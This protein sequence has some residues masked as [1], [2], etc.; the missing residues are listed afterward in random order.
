[1]RKQTLVLF[2]IKMGMDCSQFIKELR[3]FGKDA[4]DNLNGN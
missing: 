4:Y 1:M 3:L 2:F